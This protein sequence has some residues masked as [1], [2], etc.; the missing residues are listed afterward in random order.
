MAEK[1]D[2]EK[3]KLE[4]EIKEI[5]LKMLAEKSKIELEKKISFR[6]NLRGWVTLLIAIGTL[7]T[8]G[9]T[10]GKKTYSSLTSSATQ[11]EV[12]V[13]NEMIE[14]VNKLSASEGAGRDYAAVILS[15]YGEEAVPILL[16]SLEWSGENP[17]TLIDALKLIKNRD[18]KKD[19]VLVSLLKSA[20][21]VFE[22]ELPNL[23][24]ESEVSSSKPSGRARRK[25]LNYVQA[26]REVGD[27]EGMEVKKIL[28]DLQDKIEK[29]VPPVKQVVIR[30]IKEEIGKAF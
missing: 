15:S 21:V 7:I 9:F 24:K 25:I 23:Q 6:E 2:L 27:E 18:I 26:L 22:R 11:N 12:K 4:A 10:I 30:D 1:E 5:E 28:I 29:R 20:K 16:K 19:Y 13:T 17:E 3:Q 8:G 14:L